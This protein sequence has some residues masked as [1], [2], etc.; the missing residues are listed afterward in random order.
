MNENLED[1]IQ[2]LIQL[3]K[4][5][6]EPEFICDIEE[7]LNSNLTLFDDG[8]QSIQCHEIYLQFTGKVEKVLEDFVRSQSISEET[9]FNYCKQLYE[10]DPQAL[11]CFEYILAACDYN[12]FLE[13]MLTR[14]NLLEWRGEQ[15]LS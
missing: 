1:T 8:E 13:M 5:F 11:T 3:E 10:N 14:K 12:D 4:V 9:V 2:V 15:D 6:T 7:L